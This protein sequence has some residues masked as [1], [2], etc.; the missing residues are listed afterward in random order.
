MSCSLDFTIRFGFNRFA[1]DF[2]GKANKGISIL[3][4]FQ[5][6]CRH[7]PFW[8]WGI[9]IEKI[10]ARVCCQSQKPHPLV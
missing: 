7:L 2:Q 5:S 1:A 8:P 9:T 3:D 10:Y 4:D 6:L